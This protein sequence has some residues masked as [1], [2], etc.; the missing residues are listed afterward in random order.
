[1]TVS[2]SIYKHINMAVWLG[3]LDSHIT[4]YLNLDIY[5][6]MIKYIFIKAFAFVKSGLKES[7]VLL[8]LASYNSLIGHVK[9]IRINAEISKYAIE[10]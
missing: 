2:L 1:M 5:L 7:I 4:S 10:S 9:V 8:I 3:T 6:D